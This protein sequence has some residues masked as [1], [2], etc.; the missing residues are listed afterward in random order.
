MPTVYV[1]QI[2]R[3][4]DSAT[5]MFVPTVNIAPAEEHGKVFN[6]LPS[7][8]SFYATADLV[9]QLKPILKE[10]SYENGDSIIA[11]GDPSIMA[12]VFGMVGA[13][14]GKFYILKW[15]RMTSRY[16]KIKVVL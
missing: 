11:I 14:N 6:M 2:P 4:R 9:A 15:D 10:Y 13:L 1:P 8:I 3:R 16:V 5:N 12:V 7:D